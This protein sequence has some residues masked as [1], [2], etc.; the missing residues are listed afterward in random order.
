LQGSARLRQG[1]QHRLIARK[2]GGCAGGCNERVVLELLPNNQEATM[3]Q[4]DMPNFSGL[5]QAVMRD[6]QQTAN[7]ISTSFKDVADSMGDALNE[8]LER[9]PHATLAIA[10]GIGFL[11]G[12]AW[13][14]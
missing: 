11:F 14:R 8:S 3:T 7:E 1:D 6:T 2:R 12:A 13:A 10:A 9:R 4:T 5:A